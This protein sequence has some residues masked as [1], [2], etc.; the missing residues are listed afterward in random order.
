MFENKLA[1]L[2]VRNTHRLRQSQ[3]DTDKPTMKSIAVRHLV[4]L[5]QQ[6]QQQADG[7]DVAS[8][9]HAAHIASASPG[10]L[11]RITCDIPAWSVTWLVTCRAQ[12]ALC[13]AV[14]NVDLLDYRR[15]CLVLPDFEMNICIN[16]TLCQP[17]RY[18]FFNY[19]NSAVKWLFAFFLNKLRCSSTCGISWSDALHRQV[20]CCLTS[21]MNILLVFTQDTRQC[22]R[23]AKR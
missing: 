4:A 12:I 6:Q 23:E 3:R 5:H 18:C 10:F 20:P 7:R 13:R 19:N 2:T 9:K 16:S 8:D 21:I 1:V 15:T 14:R 17:T 11:S 22:T